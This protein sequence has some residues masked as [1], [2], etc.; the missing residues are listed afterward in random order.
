MSTSAVDVQ[1]L[2]IIDVSVTSDTIGVEL[3]DGRTI[4]IPLAWYPR[5]QYSSDKERQQW[6]FIG[7]GQG[8]H[9]EEI[10]EDISIES[11]LSGKRS[12][13]SQTSFK[14]WLDSRSNV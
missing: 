2:E 13:E 7:H 5:L 8:I 1:H 6:R 3:S 10:D 14:K 12:L 4:S 11:I 9:W